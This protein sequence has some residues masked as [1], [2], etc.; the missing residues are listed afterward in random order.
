M[1]K[2]D[3]LELLKNDN[4]SKKKIKTWLKNEA[5]KIID[6]IC[7]LLNMNDNGFAI[8]YGVSPSY[9][10]LIRSKKQQMGKP[11]AIK[12]LKDLLVREK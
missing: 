5:P 10:S 7:I 2:S 6:E 9:V 8:R 12:V 3:I 1:Q 4:K 11:L